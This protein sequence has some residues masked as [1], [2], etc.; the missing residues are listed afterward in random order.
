MKIHLRANLV[1]ISACYSAGSSSNYSGEGLVGLAWAFLRAGAHHVIAGLWEVDDRATPDFMDDFY[2][3]LKAPKIA[4]DAAE[5]LRSAKLNML[6][7]KGAHRLPYY[8][9]SLVL[10]S[11]S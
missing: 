7:A 9:A 4:G 1:T 3:K 10:Y 8:W 11:G 6:Q 2:S 5:A